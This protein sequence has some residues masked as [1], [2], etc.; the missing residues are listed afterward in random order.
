MIII[1]KYCLG[2]C[3]WKHV[4]FHLTHELEI[5]LARWQ[6]QQ[7]Y[8][9]YLCFLSVLRIL[10]YGPN[11]CMCCP[12]PSLL[13]FF[14]EWLLLCSH[15]FPP[16][17]VQ[18]SRVDSAFHKC[19]LD[20]FASHDYSFCKCPSQNQKFFLMTDCS[21]IFILFQQIHHYIVKA[22]PWDLV[23]MSVSALQRRD[24]RMKGLEERSGASPE[25]PITALRT[26]FGII[27]AKE[28]PL[29]ITCMTLKSNLENL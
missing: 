3:L 11:I 13:Y 23:L 6:T 1:T 7:R 17:Q 29:C 28:W 12:S 15:V 5:V 20:T 16:L 22:K 8:E 24:C 14:S 25:E 9:C 18:H 2:F 21:F 26:L 10:W 4:G 19:F 27:L